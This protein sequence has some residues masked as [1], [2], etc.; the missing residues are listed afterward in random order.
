MT[1]GG[2]ILWNAVAICEMSKTSWQTGNLRMNEDLGIIQR[3]NHSIRR[4]SGI[5]PKL[6]ERQSENPS[7]RKESITRNFH[8]ICCDRGVNL[9][10]EKYQI[11]DIEELEK[12]D[13]SETYPRRPNAQECPD[14]PE[15]NG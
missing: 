6:R 9:E 13:A 12:L 3:T 1:S 2:Q 7:I 10:A 4:T 8:W 14:I 11:A 5:T 15:K